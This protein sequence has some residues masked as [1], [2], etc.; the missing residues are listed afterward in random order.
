MVARETVIHRMHRDVEAL[1]DGMGRV[2]RRD[3]RPD[4]RARDRVSVGGGRQHE[5]EE[6]Q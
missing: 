6:R 5:E 3:R 2:A 1:G 4:V